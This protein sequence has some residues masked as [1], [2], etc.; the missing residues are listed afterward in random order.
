MNKRDYNWEETMRN[1][2]KTGLLTVA[3]IAL[4]SAASA[5]DYGNFDGYTLRV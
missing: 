5:Q 1:I 3:A 2:T 4:T